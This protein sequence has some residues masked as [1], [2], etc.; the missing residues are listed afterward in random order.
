MASRTAARRGK[1]SHTKKNEWKKGC[2]MAL[3]K[4]QFENILEGLRMEN[5]G[6]FT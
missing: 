2:Q 1:E 6:I 3:Q 5:V 4:S